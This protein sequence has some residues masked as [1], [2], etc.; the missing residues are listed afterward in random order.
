ML[1]GTCALL[2][3]VAACS[4]ISAN[5][6]IDKAQHALTQAEQRGAARSAVYEYTAAAEYLHKA[7]EEDAHAEFEAARTYAQRAAE[8]AAKAEQRVVGQRAGMEH[9]HPEP[10]PPPRDQQQVQSGDP[11]PAEQD[12]PPPPPNNGPIKRRPGGAQ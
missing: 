12:T 9:Y 7:R 4:P 10:L 6:E 1:R 2:L 11:P 5:R 3:L 8:Y